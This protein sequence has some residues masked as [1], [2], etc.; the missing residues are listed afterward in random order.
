MSKR[1][2]EEEQREEQ[3]KPNLYLELTILSAES[4]ESSS[5]FPFCLKP[6]VTVSTPFKP[7]TIFSTHTS[8]TSTSNPTFNQTFN[9]PLNPSFLSHSSSK[10]TKKEHENAVHISILSNRPLLLGPTELGCCRICASDIIDG[11][12]PPSVRRR[13]SYSLRSPR[14]GCKGHGYVHVAAR[15]VGSGVD[16]LTVGRPVPQLGWSRMAIGIPV[17]VPTEPVPSI[18]ISFL[19]QVWGHKRT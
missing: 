10:R 4:L 7:D 12:H 11:Y 15:V 16:G 6:Y 9:L 5:V 19:E 1:K 17:D 2:R 3:D 18:P 8:Q 14:D 13:L